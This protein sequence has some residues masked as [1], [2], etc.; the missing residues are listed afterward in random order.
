M[1]VSMDN[2]IVQN[3]PSLNKVAVR[4]IVHTGRKKLTIGSEPAYST[5]RWTGDR[6]ELFEGD[7]TDWKN[8]KFYLQV[9]KALRIRIN[10]L[11]ISYKIYNIEHFY[12]HFYAHFDQKHSNSFVND[13]TMVFDIKEDIFFNDPSLGIPRNYQNL[14]NISLG[15]I[16]RTVDVSEIGLEV[17]GKGL[18]Q[19]NGDRPLNLAME[20]L[21]N[22]QDPRIPYLAV[23]ATSWIHVYPLIHPITMIGRFKDRDQMRAYLGRYKIKSEDKTLVPVPLI[24]QG[25]YPLGKI[26][27]KNNVACFWGNW[28]NE[29]MR[30]DVLLAETNTP[31]KCT[32]LEKVTEFKLNQMNDE[33]AEIKLLFFPRLDQRYFPSPQDLQKYHD[34]GLY[35]SCA[36]GRWKNHDYENARNAILD[37]LH[38]NPHQQIQQLLNAAFTRI[39]DHQPFH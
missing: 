26:E 38:A 22:L 30:E 17:S 19:G 6:W 23:I 18:P 8:V 32:T 35:G 11:L 12:A 2:Q 3:W 27:D 20:D 37:A 33:T 4:K 15:D 28:G 21:A 39:I 16:I 24:H 1:T 10:D 7:I 9:K 34:Q 13:S 25:S 5:Y 14:N 31:M 29:H 36:Y